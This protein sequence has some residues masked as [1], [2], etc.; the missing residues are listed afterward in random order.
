MSMARGESGV[1]VRGLTILPGW[2]RPASLSEEHLNKPL[3]KVRE[4]LFGYMR[5]KQSQQTEPP[6]KRL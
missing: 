4:E 6:A 1:H 5:E 2:S 3:Q